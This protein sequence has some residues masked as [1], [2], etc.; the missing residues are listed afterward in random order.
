MF[1]DAKLD[2]LFYP[3]MS[4][5]EHFAPTELRRALQAMGYKHSAATQLG[6]QRKRVELVGSVFD[7]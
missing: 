5:I 1:I 6:A 7:S 3:F 4:D 2:K